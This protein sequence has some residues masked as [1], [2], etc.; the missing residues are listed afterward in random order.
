MASPGGLKSPKSTATA[1][2]WRNKVR[3][4]LSQVCPVD[5]VEQAL[6]MVLGAP[7]AKQNKARDEHCQP[8]KT[9]R[10][11]EFLEAVLGPKVAKSM[12]GEG[13]DDP[14]SPV[15]SMRQL[16]SSVPAVGQEAPHIYSPKARPPLQS[17]PPTSPPTSARAAA[18][19]AAGAAHPAPTS[20][21][22]DAVVVVNE[23]SNLDYVALA[24]MGVMLA[25]VAVWCSEDAMKSVE[26][27]VNK[28]A[29]YATATLKLDAAA[30]A[31]V[32]KVFTVGGTLALSGGVVG[33]AIMLLAS[34]VVFAIFA[35][36]N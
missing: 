27:E 34:V 2:G 12:M 25:V 30:M 4:G 9:V 20:S 24:A 33:A 16:T 14:A 5:K 8:Y 22:A 21:A 1:S 32:T 10:W 29:T 31:W 26:L 15:R 18:P 3:K 11:E 36:R 23:Q 13:G 17:P 35:N 19:A 7:E 28:L 6:A